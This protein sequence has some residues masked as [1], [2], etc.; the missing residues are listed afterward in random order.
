MS[1]PD[2]PLPDAL[3][4]VPAR[5][6]VKDVAEL[7]LRER[8]GSDVDGLVRVASGVDRLGY[9]FAVGYDAALH[10]MVPGARG[11]AALAATE[12]K[13]AHPRDIHTRVSVDGRV[14][15]EKS[16]VTLGHLAETILVVARTDTPQADGR[17]DLRL[18]SVAADAPGV[19]RE[20]LRPTP[21]APELPHA[22]V[23]FEDAAGE[24]LPGD[25]YALYMKPFRTVEDLWVH[26]ALVAWL[27][28]MASRDGWGEP[29]LADARALLADSRALLTQDLGTPAAHVALAALID[30]TR[31]LVDRAAFSDALAAEKAMFERDKPLLWVAERA[32]TERLSKARAAIP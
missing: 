28:G 1:P 15:G 14:T 26:V 5:I 4:R 2:R 7:L 18:V 11:L 19:S 29:Y 10:Q 24:M 8:P 6:A 32:R 20:A 13:S 25:G 27:F 12:N 16:F 9:A 3:A 30:R 23:R 21:F 17:P 22:R 31:G